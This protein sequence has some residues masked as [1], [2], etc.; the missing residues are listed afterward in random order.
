MVNKEAAKR[1]PVATGSDITLGLAG[2]I[3]GGKG[4]HQ[5]LNK[6]LKGGLGNMKK[7]QDTAKKGLDTSRNFTYDKPIYETSGKMKGKRSGTLRNVGYSLKSVGGKNLGDFYKKGTQ[8]IVSDTIRTKGK[9][10]RFPGIAK[11]SGFNKL[12]TV[13]AVTA[14]AGAIG[15]STNPADAYAFPVGAGIRAGVNIVKNTGKIGTK[16]RAGPATQ[17]QLR[18]IADLQQQGKIDPSIPLPKTKGFAK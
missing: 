17:K 14:G 2:M 1:G 3:L 8:K 16:G 7:T 9:L 18:F 4:L 11:R 13:G 12:S 6:L 5:G 10:G 15:I